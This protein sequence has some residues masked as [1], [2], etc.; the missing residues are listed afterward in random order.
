MA[1]NKR[2]EMQIL[3]DK[4]LVSELLLKGKGPTEIALA[5]NRRRAYN[6]TESQIRYD[7][8]RIQREWQKKYLDNY[9]GMRAQ[10]LARIDRLEEEY[11][12]AWSRSRRLKKKVVKSESSM[13]G[14]GNFEGAQDQSSKKEHLERTAG[15]EKF[16]TGI[17][18]CIDKRCEILGLDS[19]AELSVTWREKAKRYDMDPDQAVEELANQFA[20]M[21][22]PG[23][24]KE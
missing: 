10:E 23:L 5:V 20:R 8:K 7:I 13:S 9:D 18:W 6:L 11:W 16:L 14:T 2:T 21:A 17:K 19:P 22:E 3:K 15:N 24:D 12:E 1:K 4:A